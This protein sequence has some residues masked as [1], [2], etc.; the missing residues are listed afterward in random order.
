V[1]IIPQLAVWFGYAAMF[2]GLLLIV[3]AAL[4]AVFGSSIEFLATRAPF[5][6]FDVFLA[7]ICFYPLGFVGCRVAQRELGEAGV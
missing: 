5:S 6:A 3:G 4:L 7:G 2:M 1:R